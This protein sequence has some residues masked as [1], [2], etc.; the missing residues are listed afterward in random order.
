MWSVITRIFVKNACANKKVPENPVVS[1]EMDY[2][3]HR[4]DMDDTFSSRQ[5]GE[6]YYSFFVLRN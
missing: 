2:G 4:K 6:H 1:D 5:V 3:D